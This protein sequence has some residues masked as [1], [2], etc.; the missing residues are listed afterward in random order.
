MTQCL[1]SRTISGILKD[2]ARRFA[3]KIAYRDEHRSV[4]YTELAART[5]RLAGNLAGRGVG[6]N[7]RVALLL[8]NSIEAIE[9]LLAITRAA[10]VGVPLNPRGSDAELGFQL[11]D[12]D[13]VLVITDP[14]HEPQVR[15]ICDLPVLV[16]GPAFEQLATTAT[17][18]PPD[19]LPLDDPA[20]ILYTSGTSGRA[21]GV[22]SNQRAALWSVEAGYESV[23]GL[24]PHDTLLWPLPLYHSFAHSFCILGVIAVGASARILP[25][26]VAEQVLATLRAGSYTVLGGVPTIYR[27][28]AAGTDG[29]V[30]G[31]RICLTAGAPSGVELRR[32]FEQAFGTP[33]LDFYGST[34]TCGGVTMAAPGSPP[35]AGSP[36]IPGQQVRVVDPD[37]GEDVPLGDEGE[38]WLRGPNLMLGYHGRPALEP[39]EWHHT[40]DVGRF[41]GYGR[42][43]ITGRRNEV[44]NCGGEKFHPA[45]VEQVLAELPEV[46]DVA[47]TGRADEL[48]GE[49]PVAYV[50]AAPFEPDRLR[51]ACRRAL[52]ASKVPVEFH[53]IGH[54]PRTASGKAL[55]RQLAV[56]ELDLLDVVLRETAAV[57]GLTEQD[58]LASD[59]P[60]TELG[61]TSLLAVELCARLSGHAGRKLPATLL[62]EFPTPGQLA[63]HL[64]QAGPAQ[65]P[66]VPTTAAEPIAIIGMA[67]RYPGGVHSPADLWQLLVDEV[68]ATSEFPADR[69]WDLAGL[70]DDDPDR[71]GHT[72]LRRGGFLHDAA[73]FD[74]APFGITPRAALAMDPQ[75]RLLLET[76]LEAFERAGIDPASLRESDTGVFAGVMYNDYASRIQHSSA[77]VEAQLGLGSAASVA[78]GRIAYTFGLRGPAITVDTAC[79]SS[80]VA[81]HWAAAALR[82]GECS[83]ALAGGATVMCTPN[84][85]VQ[86]SRSRALA[87]DGRCKPFSANSDGAVWSEGAGLLVLQRLSDARRDGHPVLAVLRGSAV[88][89][90]GASNG[91]TAPSCSAQQRVIE[92]ALAAA[93]LQPGDVDVVEAHGTGTPLGD[94]I[95]ARALIAAYTPGRPADRPLQL[96]SIKANLGH[97]QA[98]A[99][100]AGVIKMVEAMRYGVLPATL[101]VGVPTPEVDWP[102]TIEI[103]DRTRPWPDTGG[104]RLAA[105]SSFGIS[106]TNAHVILE[107]AGEPALVESSVRADVEL[108]WLLSSATDVRAQAAE[109]VEVV[110][111]LP[112]SAVGHALARRPAFTQRAAVLSPA[113]LPALAA[114]ESDPRVITGVAAARGKLAFLFSGQGAQRPD[115]GESLRVFP[116]FADAFD[117]V[118]RFLDPLLDRPVRAVITGTDQSLLDRADFTQ[119]ALFAF[120]VALFRLLESWGMRPAYL[121]G[122]SFGELAAAHVAGVLTIRDAAELVAARGALMRDL[123]S[124]GAM[125][126]VEADE[127]EVLASIAG[128]EDRLGVAAVNA[129][130]SVVLSGAEP[131]VLAVAA[132]FAARGRRTKRLGLRLATHSPLVEPMLDE[133]RAVAARL[134]YQDPQIPVVSGLTGRIAEPGTLSNAE[135][136]VRH[137]RQP[138][139][140]ADSVRTLADAGVSLFAELGPSSVLSAPAQ[141]TT[142]RVVAPMA[143]SV[144]AAVAKLWVH[145]AEL[146]RAAMFSGSPIAAL[147]TYAFQHSR[148]WLEDYREDQLAIAGTGQRLF[149]RTLSVSAHPW[150]AD[151]RIAGTLVVPAA[152]LIEMTMRA[153]EADLAEFLLRTPMVLPETGTLTVQVLLDESGELTLHARH[154][155]T[156]PWVLHATGRVAHR[157]VPPESDE[158]P[159]FESNVDSVDVAYEVLARR[160]YHYG[161]A[162]QCVRSVHRAGDTIY[163]EARVPDTGRFALHPALLDAVAHSTL[164]VDEVDGPVRL[165]FAWTGV[166]LYATGATAVRA[167]LTPTGPD[168]VAVAIDDYHGN[169]VARVDALVVRPLPADAIPRADLPLLRPAWQPVAPGSARRDFDVRELTDPAPHVVDRTHSLVT[170]TLH[171]LH[172]SVD[173]DRPLVLVAED[174]DPATMAACGL[175]RVAQHEHPGRFVLVHGNA[176]DRASLAD[177]VATGEPEVS[178]V[179]AQLRVPRLTVA[180]A[181]RSRYS[182]DPDGT[183][184]ITGGTG[185]LGSVLARHLQA[186]HGIRRIVLASRRGPEAPGAGELDAEVVSCNVGDRAD[187][188]RLLAE[189]GPLSMVVH[190]AGV[191]DD[192]ILTALTPDRMTAVLRAKADAAWWL[193]ELVGDSAMLVLFSSATGLLGNAGQG[194]YAAANAFLDGLAN[195]RRALGMPALSLAWG[196]W[197]TDH[198]M[199]AQAARSPSLVAPVSA[200]RGLAMFDAALAGDEP[201][202]APIALD[203]RGVRP[204]QPIPP[205]LRGLL[206]PVLPAAVRTGPSAQTGDRDPLGLVLRAVANVLGHRDASAIA[207]EESF[208][209]IG[210]DSLTS[211]ELRNELAGTVGTR[212]PAT[213]VFDHP[214]PAALA[215]HL[216]SLVGT[217]APTAPTT[218]GLASLYRRICERG[219]VVLGMHLLVSAAVVTPS[220]GLADLGDHRITPATLARG[221]RAPALICLPSFS[222]VPGEYT[223]LAALFDGERD[224][225]VLPHP[226]YV[227]SAVPADRE[228]LIRLHANAVVELTGDRPFLL[229][230]RSSGGCVAHAV[231]TELERAGAAPGG[232]VL[233]DTFHV[234][235][236]NEDAEWL[237][238]LPARSA[239]A[240]GAGFDALPD[241]AVVAMGAYTSIFRGWQP[242]KVTAP[243]L[244]LR[245]ADAVA[246]ED[247]PVSHDLV[248]VPGDHFSIVEEHA[249][250]TVAAIRA[251]ETR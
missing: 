82:A 25:G 171:W 145:G 19:D 52:T 112:A 152:V 146:D 237:L 199:A 160:G 218:S 120:E 241:S 10:A 42:L 204:G 69:G 240:L 6:R 220:F 31:P 62:F 11:H 186:K 104:P 75:Q 223:R 207:P 183:V 215:G 66:P 167:K 219:E 71:A 53:R 32:A 197:D 67:C 127:G 206:Q 175:I 242:E 135:Y 230:G 79:S 236:H 43:E 157:E 70:F 23:L 111:E 200:E 99:G 130:R 184:L 95:E 103:T 55:R 72:Y 85:F 84:S 63:Q 24:G 80:L 205:M 93:R 137:V 182:F 35:S 208:A 76:A 246:D 196:L 133:F 191:I 4:T 60:F 129:R 97:T 211:M 56:A 122:H 33:L 232:V 153:T 136:W 17:A 18:A 54:I 125:V 90:D 38:V 45:E 231:A 88:N 132:H 100:V 194:N 15:R 158:W 14:V 87:P 213:V 48:L 149:T 117:H 243:T 147:P 105:V 238:A 3:D 108:P 139:R 101:N 210:F 140:F 49:V 41:T 96:G 229:V 221:E 168:T 50:V 20:W 225:H 47:V 148:F 124:G 13:P 123:P 68:D 27:Q 44:I 2:N 107:Q 22:V 179:D 251:W 162:F 131:E 12:C 245:A 121:A 29:T 116:V 26:F 214:T 226:S 7:M 40:G 92:R 119:A 163:T 141:E 178:T 248:R 190:A 98:A 224:V 28:L 172:E 244:L 143:P 209:A 203:Q 46:T 155:D 188:A 239:L 233:I 73:E 212:L 169:P 164:F 37:T 36:V 154:D 59:R 128:L 198:G 109:L 247:W 177:A 192:G 57:A 113:A 106:G 217:P 173:G 195:H 89:S 170:R 74:P 166:R 202:L 77:E 174:S 235:K 81:M 64:R 94:S 115:M 216:A 156:A 250:T 234:T 165:P 228:T 185:A 193:H 150:L 227:G 126:S 176:A 142:D 34:E 83:L 51:A 159:A 58:A 187:L 5:E 161:P 201:V 86:F 61:V 8:G 102:A 249:A 180:P 222:P 30:P 21:R 91:L 78:S 189:L 114:G 39:G 118:C 144:T 1:Q 9:G 181:S 16:T 65:R 110:P 134:S 151:H 138:V